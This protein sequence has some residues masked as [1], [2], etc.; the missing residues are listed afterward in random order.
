MRCLPKNIR[1][2]NLTIL[3]KALKAQGCQKSKRI[4]LSNNE[5][6]SL[7]S[8][9]RHE[10]LECA[11]TSYLVSEY[12]KWSADSNPGGNPLLDAEPI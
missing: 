3:G 10:M 11:D 9:R 7:L 5:T 6:I 4:K 1:F 8:V 12:E 2:M